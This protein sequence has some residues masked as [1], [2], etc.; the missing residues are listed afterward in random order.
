MDDTVRARDVQRTDLDV[1][2]RLPRPRELPDHGLLASRRR[3]Q[4]RPRGQRG[5]CESM[6]FPGT[7]RA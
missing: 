7:E 1:E 4:P 6:L 2:K 5:T 3:S